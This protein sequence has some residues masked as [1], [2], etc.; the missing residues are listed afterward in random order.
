MNSYQ[1][2]TIKITDFLSSLDFNPVKTNTR[3][4]WYL[5]PLSNEKT[6]SF[7]VNHILNAFYCFSTGQGGTIIDLVMLMYSCNLKEA[8]DILSGGAYVPFIKKESL[9]ICKQPPKFE[10]IKIKNLV[11]PLLINYL[12]SRG[13]SPE[14][15]FNYL[16][17]IYFNYGKTSY[18][19]LCFPNDSR[20]GYDVRYNNFKG[21]VGASKDISTVVYVPGSPLLV[22]EGFM[23][24][25]SYLTY[26]KK[27]SLKNSVI[28]LNSTCLVS[29]A[30]EKIKGLDISKI[31]LLLDNDEAGKNA[32]EKIMD[33]VNL[34]VI[35]KADIYKNNK[36][37][38]DFLCLQKGL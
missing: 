35:D 25:L 13:I 33:E 34:E 10:I 16:Q 36:D 14:L 9:E 21:Y 17:E 5:S 19:G 15:A 26:F 27:T 38:N 23:D 3:E 37:F 22:F 12:Q 18:F 29:R 24:F 4:S 20:M 2:K 6:A 30:I 8:L 1:A 28:V 32:T 7:K 11:S 31:Y